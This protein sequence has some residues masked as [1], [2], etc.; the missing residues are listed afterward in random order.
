MTPLKNSNRRDLNS[1]GLSLS[2]EGDRGATFCGRPV[3][4][5][6]KSFWGSWEHGLEVRGSA[7]RRGLLGA[8]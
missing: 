7:S 5:I 6:L 3:W 4:V 2:G 1:L 8:E